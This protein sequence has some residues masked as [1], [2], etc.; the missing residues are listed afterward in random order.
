MAMSILSSSL[1]NALNGSDGVC[2]E[3]RGK[4]KGEKGREDWR[5]MLGPGRWMPFG[6]RGMRC[7]MGSLATPSVR[8]AIPD[9]T[10]RKRNGEMNQNKTSIVVAPPPF[11]KCNIGRM[12]G[13][14]ISSIPSLIHIACHSLTRTRSVAR[15]RCS[16]ITA[17]HGFAPPETNSLVRRIDMVIDFCSFLELFMIMTKACLVYLMRLFDFIAAH[18]LT[19]KM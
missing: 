12:K 3:K 4:R 1:L 15:T 19:A 14:S 2:T 10:F 8:Y 11:F 17:A 5:G 6:F 9:E 18:K 16:K 13:Q 7:Q